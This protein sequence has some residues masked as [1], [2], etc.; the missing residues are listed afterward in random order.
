MDAHL[1]LAVTLFAFAGAMTPGPNN[2][3]LVT[4]GVNFGFTRTIPHMMGITWGFALLMLVVALGLGAIFR[5][6]P[7]LQIAVKI[8]GGAYLLWLAWKIA[9][10]RSMGEA[11]RAGAPMSFLQ[12][13][14]FQWVNPK[15]LTMAIA[16]TAAYTDPA[17]YARSVTVMVV[18]FTLVTLVSVTTWTGF[19]AALKTWLAQPTRLK[20]FNRTMGALL[21]LSLWP[22]LM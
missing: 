13:A 20:W 7:A 11:K 4:S 16:A 3:M 2:L 19:G 5:E 12:A 15:G 8:L 10:S 17:R 6:V 22:M 18:V 21:V 1:I 14:A 9:L